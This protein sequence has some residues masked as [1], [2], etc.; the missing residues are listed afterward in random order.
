[1]KNLIILLSTCLI[2]FASFQSE[3]RVWRLN[4]QSGVDADVTTN[5]QDAVDTASYGDTIYV[6]QSPFDYGDAVIAK[7]L[8]IIG[9]GYWLDQN[10][11]TQENINKSQVFYL[12]FNSGSEGSVISG[13]YF[14]T[15]DGFSGQKF[16]EINTNSIT[17]QRCYITLQNPSNYS[18]LIYITGNRTNVIIQQN[19]LQF[20]FG[21]SQNAPIYINGDPGNLIIRNNICKSHL[22]T[23]GSPGKLIYASTSS[24]S[25]FVIKNNIFYGNLNT[26]NA[27]YVNN[28]MLDGTYSN[29]SGG[30]AS[31][32]LC[33]GTQYPIGNNNQR[34]LSMS[35]VFVNY[36]SMIDN[37]YILSSSSP[38]KNVGINGGDCG[39]F[40]NDYGGEPYVL[41]GIP[42]IPSI[43]DVNFN[44]TVISTNTINVTIKAKS[45]K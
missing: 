43:F 24:S 3:A 23:N 21:V 1:M 34:N 10:D 11:S 37:G 14:Y 31:N 45:N 12:V 9:G 32:N 6:E 13:L 35:S 4:N 40:S 25:T 26:Y 27:L 38:A 22:N 7:K 29:S 8:I 2:T 28:I 30:L 33:N 5:L 19:W 44:A 42:D 18:Y 39:A 20:L 36:I 41:S 17:I 15:T 16:I